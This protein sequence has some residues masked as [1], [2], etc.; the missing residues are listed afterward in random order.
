[1]HQLDCSAVA[2]PAAV[3]RSCLTRSRPRARHTNLFNDANPDCTLP[4][5]GRKQD[6]KLGSSILSVSLRTPTKAK[7]NRVTLDFGSASQTCRRICVHIC[8]PGRS[9]GG[10][11]FAG[12]VFLGSQSGNSQLL[13]LSF[14]ALSP[15]SDPQAMHQ[16]TVRN[17]A[18][19]DSLAP[20][21]DVLV[22]ED[23][24]GARLHYDRCNG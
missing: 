11:L 9:H 24:P 10:W 8:T 17:D 16:C 19:V 1:M 21:Q 15:G 22:Y 12:L 3:L 2:S 14:R 18:L 20:T 4:A 6:T 23:P 7:P 5:R 13:Q